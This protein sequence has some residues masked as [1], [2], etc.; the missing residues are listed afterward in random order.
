MISQFL[1]KPPFESA[2][3]VRP[4]LFF[5]FPIRLLNLYYDNDRR[6]LPTRAGFSFS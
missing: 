6:E 4:P 5:I 3:S 1:E 2:S